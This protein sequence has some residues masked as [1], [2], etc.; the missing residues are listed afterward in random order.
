M[1]MSGPSAEAS[2][3]LARA[4]VAVLRAISSRNSG[5]PDEEWIV[6]L[7]ADMRALVSQDIALDDVLQ[8]F[9]WCNGRFDGAPD[10]WNLRTERGKKSR[11]HLCCGTAF[12]LVLPRAPVQG[13]VS[14][15]VCFF[16]SRLMSC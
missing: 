13:C 14:G 6:A 2:S 11:T 10:L 1:A 8:K 5:L 3:S 9:R 4:T 15:R 7:E 16:L 12:S